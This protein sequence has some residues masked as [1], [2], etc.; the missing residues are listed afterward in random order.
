MPRYF[1]KLSYK[2]TAFHGWQ[3]QENADTVQAHVERALAIL[4]GEA[5]TFL[6][7]G[8]TD[9]GVHAR[10]YYGH[11]DAPAEIV[12]GDKFVYKL[13]AILSHDIS[14]HN[15]IPVLDTAHARFDATARTYEYHI[16]HHKDPFL[17]GL[18]H[19]EPQR[20][21]V[22]L[23]NKA[24][25]LL[26]AHSDFGAFA[27][28]GTQVKTN[29]CKV[30][31]AHFDYRDQLLVFTITADR[32]LRNMVRAVTGTLMHVGKHIITVDE[33]AAI[34]QSQSRAEAGTSMPAEGLYLTSIKYPYIQHDG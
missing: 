29:L 7:C 21:D 33:F 4:C 9:T 14:F 24:A 20:P 11:F 15:V 28:S 25:H 31:E 23:M 19:Y 17:R 10:M 34:M 5:V 1:G 13:N 12:E 8:R 16:Y 30:T 18:A 32:F 27:K 26:L 6:G 2:G 22:P 3:V